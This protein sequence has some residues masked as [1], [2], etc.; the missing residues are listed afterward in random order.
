MGFFGR[1]GA[2]TMQPERLRDRGEAPPVLAADE[3]PPDVNTWMPGFD[4]GAAGGREGTMKPLDLPL[5]SS[6][7]EV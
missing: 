3:V 1:H 7:A 4:P 6:V 5:P 2:E